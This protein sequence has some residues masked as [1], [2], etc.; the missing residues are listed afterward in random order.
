M[1]QVQNIS[2][3]FKET[4]VLTDISIDFHPGKINFIIGRSGQGKSVLLKCMVGLLEPDAGSILYDG[5][6][7]LNMDE[8]QHKAIRQEVGMLFQGAALFDSMTVEEN[9]MFPLTMYSNLTYSE[10]L[11]KV[12]ECLE[13]V[14]LVGKNNLYPAELSGGMK[15]R[16]GIARAI[17]MNP[18]FL[19]VDEPNSGLDPETSIVIDNLIR[20][21]TYDLGS[22]TIVVSHDMNSVMEIGDSIN[23]ISGGRVEWQ[24][25]KHALLKA[26]NEALNNFVFASEF[27]QEIKENLRR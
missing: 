4:R 23:F 6:D 16:T 10:K 3:S 25:D 21:I 27:M 5:V 13:R 26:E 15:K 24:G 17:I 2:K 8:D 11:Q 18:K 9:V 20:N 1:I 19:F 14:N 12:N 7:F 22:T